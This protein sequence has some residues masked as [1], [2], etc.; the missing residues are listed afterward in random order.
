MTKKKSVGERIVEGL[1]EAI[2][3]Q[4]GEL[5]GARVTRVR[6]TAQSADV[7]AAPRYSGARVAR[8]RSQLKLSQPV[9][10]KALNVS[11]ETVRS[12][13]QEKRAP[14]GA[15]QR[16]L[17]VAERHPEVILENIRQRSA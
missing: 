12:W 5:A 11:P 8:L 1:E 9:F 16:L 14:D 13:E 4:R 2:A 7:K 17:E 6:L 10:A 15:A 3:Y